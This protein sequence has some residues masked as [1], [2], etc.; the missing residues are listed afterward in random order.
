M[1]RKSKYLIILVFILVVVSAMFF[2]YA[3]INSPEKYVYYKGDPT[4]YEQAVCLIG[5]GKME[6]TEDASGLP[7]EC[8]NQLNI[9]N[10]QC[11]FSESYLCHYH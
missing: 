10:M 5:G 6:V 3:T 8:L 4:Y 1:H 9:N 2:M 7:E 11:S